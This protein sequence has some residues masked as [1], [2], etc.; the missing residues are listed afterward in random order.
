MSNF[1]LKLLAVEHATW[2]YDP[3]NQIVMEDLLEICGC[4]ITDREGS[5]PIR[6][7]HYT[8]RE[9]LTSERIKQG[10][11]SHFYITEGEARQTRA[12]ASL[13]L[14][15]FAYNSSSESSML[16]VPANAEKNTYGLMLAFLWGVL[17]TPFGDPH[18]ED[19]K[20]DRATAPQMKRLFN[21][22]STRYP[23]LIATLGVLWNS[24]PYWDNPSAELRSHVSFAYACCFESVAFAEL[25][26]KQ[27]P[28]ILQS[29]NVIRYNIFSH[30]Q[31][32]L[33]VPSCAYQTPL[34]AAIL[35][36]SVGGVDLLLKHGTDPN[37][38]GQYCIARP[39]MK[40][41]V[42]RWCADLYL[43]KARQKAS[44][45]IIRMLLAAG[46]NPNP[47]C[48]AIT[49]LQLAASYLDFELVQELLRMGA[50]VNGTGDDAATARVSGDIL[51]RRSNAI[52]LEVVIENLGT[53][54]K[55]RHATPLQI[56]M[57]ED[58]SNSNRSGIWEG[59]PLDNAY[60]GFQRRANW[61]A[62][63]G[64]R[65]HPTLED[66]EDERKKVVD[67]LVNHGGEAFY[68]LPRATAMRN[69]G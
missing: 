34:V 11:A 14:L 22:Q 4:L 48:V 16:V 61:Y 52:E 54:E 8:V 64:D 39:L 12:N 33:F 60:V 2:T 37:A 50:H 58:V 17:I 10:R 63:C 59:S 6:L 29:V 28:K 32:S 45:N 13:A 67:I 68:R 19:P 69:V 3:N 62:S 9:Y 20:L 56:A 41:L 53:Q 46:A 1:F 42:N 27:Y 36:H 44:I 24:L 26:I 21:E 49:P 47:S 15:D 43:H 51:T 25:I 57:I 66:I 31:S 65:R 7:A 40:A 55:I 38:K 5:N 23:E 30:Q 18:R 35:C